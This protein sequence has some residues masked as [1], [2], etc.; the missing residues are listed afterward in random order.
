MTI[1][2][3]IHQKALEVVG[4]FKRA[5]A[6]LIDVLQQADEY[7]VYL[8]FD[9]RSLYEY[10]V[11]ILKLSEGLAYNFITVA[12]KAKEV[13]ELKQMIHSGAL[14]VSKARKI[15]PILTKNNK[16]QWLQMAIDL[17]QK[18]LEQ[19]VAKCCPQLA[20]PEKIK[21]VAE[22][23][24]YLQ[25]GISDNLNQKFRRAQDL[26]SQ[27]KQKPVTMEE[28]L[29]AL[30]DV[31]FQYRD[32]LQKTEKLKNRKTLAVARQVNLRD[33]GQCTFK[34]KDGHRCTEKRW[35][36]LHHIIP[37]SLGGADTLE[38]LTTLCSGHHRLMHFQM[39]TG[40]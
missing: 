14:S 24:F 38:N 37:R 9:C 6:D 28:T 1:Q 30:L 25:L 5:E 11:K 21:F 16:S 12:R 2:M 7:K 19:E 4:Q 23:R 15:T 26:E 17:P 32:P 8:R 31:Y 10:S 22:D 35:L 20:T 13:P 34:N 29:D 40:K 27:K 18:K 33:Q 36:H 39:E 3:Q